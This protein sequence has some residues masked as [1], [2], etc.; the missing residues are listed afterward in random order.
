MNGEPFCGSIALIRHPEE[1]EKLWLAFWDE[2][3]GR[4]DFVTAERLEGDSFRECLDRE[5]AWAL[6]IRRGKDYIVSSMARLHLEIPSEN[7][8]SEDDLH[9]IEFFVAD[10]YGKR[11]RE[12]V[13]GNDKLHW[14]MSSEV[15]DGETEDGRP[16]NP[17]LV[18]WLRQADVIARHSQY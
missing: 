3:R 5:I 9:M 15:L 4:F 18:A 10:L 13:R 1:L 11:G 17:Q 16:L 2:P 7:E 14:L 6:D 8:G 12:A